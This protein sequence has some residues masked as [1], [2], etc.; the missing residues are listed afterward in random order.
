MLLGSAA[1]Y[2]VRRH[3]RDSLISFDKDGCPR[4]QAD[5]IIGLSTIFLP[6]HANWKRF[7]EERVVAFRFTRPTKNHL[8]D[9]LLSMITS[10][11]SK[12]PLCKEEER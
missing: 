8:T 2:W 9:Q 6:A 10:A 11:G 1:Q 12:D 7:G 5:S 3:Q 4:L